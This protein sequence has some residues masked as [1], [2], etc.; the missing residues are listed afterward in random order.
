MK[1]FECFDDVCLVT[2]QA[3][4]SACVGTV[5][6]PRNGTSCRPAHLCLC[7]GE[8][9]QTARSRKTRKLRHDG[10]GR[11]VHTFARRDG[12]IDKNLL[13]IDPESGRLVF[14]SA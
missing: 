8:V 10:K 6:A 1:L 3:E 11:V 5:D 4:A 13:W 14:I 12:G 2:V 7:H 9:E